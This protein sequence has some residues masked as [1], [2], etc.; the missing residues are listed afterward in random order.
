M[1]GEDILVLFRS[2]EDWI[3]RNAHCCGDPERDAMT[4]PALSDALALHRAGRLSEA[5]AGYRAIIAATADAEAMQLLAS[6]LHQDGRSREA[7][8]WLD[9]ALPR[10]A[11]RDAAQSNRA[12]RCCWRSSADEAVASAEQ[13][14]AQSAPCGRDAQPP[15]R[16]AR[17]GAGGRRAAREGAPLCALCRRRRRSARLPPD[18]AMP[19]RTSA[20]LKRPLPRSSARVNSIRTR[21]GSRVPR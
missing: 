3:A 9:R 7:L 1:A 10:L 15:P 16:A 21:P 13:V 14:L 2:P 19:C 12:R 5:E 6:L 8:A 20:P 4:V 18:P 17:T 11:R